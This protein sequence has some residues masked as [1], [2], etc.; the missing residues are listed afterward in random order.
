VFDVETLRRGLNFRL[1]TSAGDLDLLGDVTGGGS[2]EEL[3]PFTE[4][5][6]IF[7]GSCQCVTLPTLLRLKRA[8]GRPRDLNA[9]AELEALL[10]ERERGPEKA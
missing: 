8:A 4:S 3:L 10:E 2:Y 5:V 6:P 1:T 9:I 7:D